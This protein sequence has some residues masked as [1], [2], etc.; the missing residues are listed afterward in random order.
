MP[1]RRSRRPI[2][3][4]SASITSGSLIG[5]GEPSTSGL[6]PAMWPRACA[7]GPRTSPTTRSGS[8][9]RSRS[10]PASTTAGCSDIGEEVRERRVELVRLLE[11]RQM[12]CPGEDPKAPVACTRREA[13][14]LFRREEEVALADGDEARALER[15]EG[16]RVV[17]AVSKRPHC[18]GQLVPP[19]A[20]HQ[21]ACAVHGLFRG[22]FEQQ[23][24][25]LVLP[26]RFGASV[27]DQ[28]DG[29]GTARAPFGRVT[30]GPSADKRQGANSLGRA[31]RHRERRIPAKRG[32]DKDELAVLL[33]QQG[34]RPVVERLAAPVQTRCRDL[35]VAQRLEL[36]FPHPLVQ[37]K[38]V[39]KHDLHQWSAA[40]SSSSAAIAGR[41][42]SRSSQ[43]ESASQGS[44]STP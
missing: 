14:R 43:A 41:S 33:A 35:V 12:P 39:Q 31:T 44:R 4:A 6:E 37:R 8:P 23:L 27:L 34:S 24:R 10:Q 13:L 17:C 9:S 20:E 22:V 28:G 40:V 26:E 30:F 29:V 36:R 1:W 18:F 2:S 5:G 25:A 11:T 42:L 15:R 38:S 21:V 19:A 16:L 7:F 32:A 3:F